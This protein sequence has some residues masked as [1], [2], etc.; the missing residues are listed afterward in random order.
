MPKQSLIASVLALVTASAALPTGAGAQKEGAPGWYSV[1]PI[2]RVQKPNRQPSQPLP[3]KPQP[4]PLMTIQW[5]LLQRVDDDTTE[6]PNPENVFQTGDQLKVAVT[7]NQDGYLYILNQPEG[8]DGVVLFPNP[9]VGKG[10]N[11]VSRNKQ[12]TVPDACYD[13]K[14][15][16]RFQDPNDCWFEMAPPAGRENLVV[17]FSR[18]PITTLPNAAVKPFAPVDR[19]VV[20]GLIAGS[21]KNN[22]QMTGKLNTPD[23]KT[24]PYAT[25]VQNTN[26]KDNEE[27]ITTIRLNH[28]E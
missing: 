14:N 28:R 15:P 20:D 23:G 17:I 26:V 11:K 21:E 7:V 16:E 18:E 5:H 10:L 4:A 3:K 9:A 27:I 1:V 22:S 8:K 12:Y 2:K 19:S 24:L 13:T 6:Q 25:R